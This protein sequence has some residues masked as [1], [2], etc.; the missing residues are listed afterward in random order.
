MT[1]QLDDRLRE[2]AESMA[3]LRWSAW[4]LDADW[5]LVWVSEEMKQFV[6]A[7]KDSDLG[8]GLNITEALVKDAWLSGIDPRSIQ[9]VL[10][11]VGPYM[12]ANLKS[13]GRSAEEVLPDEFLGFVQ[14]IE[15]ADPPGI[16]LTQ[17]QS[18]DPADPELP[19]YP[20]NVCAI[21]LNDPNGSLLGWLVIFFMAISPN[22]LALLARGDEQ[23]YERMARLVEPRPRQGAILFC[24]LHGS[25]EL[26]RKLSSITYF[27]LVRQLWTGI[28][29]AVAER[30]GI[31][32]KHAG[33]GAS[34]YFLVSDLGSPSEAAAASLRSAQRIH[35]LS[36]EVF[37]DTL[38]SDCLM[39]VG[40]HW[41]GSLYMGQLVPGSR[42]DVSALGDEVN[43]AA[44]IQEL[45]G[46]DETVVSK[47]LLEQLLPDD[48]ASL[49]I[50][51]EKI[52]YR[53]I[54]DVA[55]AEKVV[56]DAGNLA[57]TTL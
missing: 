25:G 17:F 15:P 24:D 4:I 49:G 52:T 16:F 13:Q 27:R 7:G 8:I 34:A 57:V 18:I 55:D 46:P 29:N 5:R 47:Q 19:P 11:E 40:I 54:H 31:I 50:D 3:K 1:E 6:R 14:G 22:L 56:R 2:Y 21:R 41:G 53:T 26:S 42:L 30:S 43:E 20:V 37:R 28:D 33:D 12:L 9:D 23:M 39:Q 36:G 51:L 48:A 35:E 45:A 10:E 44:R 38:E 32:G